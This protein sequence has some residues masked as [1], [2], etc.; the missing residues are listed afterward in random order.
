MSDPSDQDATGAYHPAPPVPPAGERFAP[1]VL[2]AG[3]YRIVAALGKGGMGEVYRA[4]D[5]TLGQSVALKFLPAELARDPERLARFRAEVRIARQVSHPH[6]C[7]VYDV[8]E[9]DGQPFLTMEYVD[10]E[11]L[12]ALLRRI[13]RLPEEKGVELARQLCLGLAA[14]HE[15]GVIHRDLKP[16][17]V[18]IDA[19]GQVRLTDFG[20]AAAGAVEDVRSG[21]PAYQAPE[22]LAGREVTAR[23]DL[24]ALGLV[25]YEMF[26]GRR[27]FPATTPAELRR[28]YADGT[29]SRPSDHVGNLNPSV[30][31]LILRCLEREPADRPRSAYEVLAGLPGGDPLAAAMAAGQTPSPEA[32]ANAPIEGTLHPLVAVALLVAI[33]FGIYGVAR[34]NDPSK[35]FRLVPLRKARPEDLA[36]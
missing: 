22:Q 25:L 11:D 3:R 10:G 5:L 33:W 16:A 31:R 27:P 36:D 28:L 26:T 24:F 23:S 34:L 8:G 14:A 29:P 32:V 17:N 18:M 30:E 19:R 13:G 7:R 15:R 6:V 4:D 20:L 35:L 21:T 1:G 12:A 9:A 2:L